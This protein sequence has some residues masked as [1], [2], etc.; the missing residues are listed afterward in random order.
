MNRSR[1]QRPGFHDYPGV[2]E[3]CLIAQ[4]HQ[5]GRLTHEPLLDRNRSNS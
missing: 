3:P 2:T 4:P 1:N 5:I